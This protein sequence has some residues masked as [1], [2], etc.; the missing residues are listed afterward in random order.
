MFRAVRLSSEGDRPV[1]PTSESDISLA[2]FV[3]SRVE[4]T[5]RRQ[6]RNRK[7]ETISRG[8]PSYSPTFAAS[9]P[10]WFDVHTTP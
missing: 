7:G 9:A 8:V 1:A 5:Q 3:L 10:L 4:G 2:K 6:V